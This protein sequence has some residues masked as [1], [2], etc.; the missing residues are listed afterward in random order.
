MS[1][2]ILSRALFLVFSTAA[3][4]CSSGESSEAVK[5]GAEEATNSAAFEDRKAWADERGLEVR[6]FDLNRDNQPNVFKF[7]KVDDSGQELIVRKDI[8]LNNDTR[9]DV[10]QLYDDDGRLVSE[11]SDLDFDGKMDV[12]SM[13]EDEVLTRKELDLNFDGTADVVR[14]YTKG[15][16]ERIETDNNGDGR[17]DTWEYFV[18]GELDRVGTDNDGDGVVDHWDRRRQ[19]E[20][21]PSEESTAQAD[22][23]PA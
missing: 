17:V 19:K 4:A 18:G 14:Y 2:R 22:G 9:V 7:F 10:V 12:K 5:A 16:I 21:V 11:E 15:K 6:Q 3:L 20:D 8:D 23:D 1:L 13:F